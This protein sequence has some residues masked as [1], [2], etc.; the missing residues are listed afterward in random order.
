FFLTSVFDQVLTGFIFNTQNPDRISV[1]AIFLITMGGFAIVYLANWAVSSL[2]FTEGTRRNILV[3]LCYTL[4]PYIITELIWI[5]V[6]NFANMELSAFMTAI[7][8]IG[9]LWASFILVVGM[10]YIHQLSFFG[11]LGNLILTAIG[12]LFILFLLLLGYTLVQ[13]I[14]TFVRTIYNEIVFRI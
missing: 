2:M 6:S 14:V 9:L 3:V 4:V 10:I 12:I 13:Q 1:P 5:L 7:R 8:V 11:T